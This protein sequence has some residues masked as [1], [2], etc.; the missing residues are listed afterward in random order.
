MR[1]YLQDLQI[2]LNQFGFQ[3]KQSTLEQF[4]RVTDLYQAKLLY[5]AFDKV[6]HLGLLD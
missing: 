4:H 2:I 3:A 1:P 6:P 5:Q